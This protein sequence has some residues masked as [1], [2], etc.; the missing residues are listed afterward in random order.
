MDE[1]LIEEKKYVS[2]KQ[3]AKITGYAKDY[4][5]QLCREG[6]VPARLVGRSWYVLES[7]IKD[8]RFGDQ[9][10]VSIDTTPVA[11]TLPQP[12]G[13][14]RYEASHAEIFPSLNRSNDTKA[15]SVSGKDELQ[16]DEDP[17]RDINESWKEWF[18]TIA[19]AKETLTD[20]TYIAI[21]KEEDMID[22]EPVVMNDVVQESLHSVDRRTLEQ[23]FLPRHILPRAEERPIY[24]NKAAK[25]DW[26]VSRVTVVIQIAGILLA[27]ISVALACIG[28]GYFDNILISSRQAMILSGGIVY[29]K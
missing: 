27:V 28:S 1:I 13:F 4:I 26:A 3:A 9:N 22:L 12:Q 18:D 11:P 29:N 23:D 16:L 20:A 7:A 6:R 17:I 24:Q 19:S 5:G 10:V 8:H 2:S 21:E 14:P 25:K 15:T